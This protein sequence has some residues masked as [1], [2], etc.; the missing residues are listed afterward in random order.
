MGV[1]RKI[2]DLNLFE[3]EPIMS[4]ERRRV[5]NDL[6]LTGFAEFRNAC[7]L[8][9]YVLDFCER[10]RLAYVFSATPRENY[11]LHIVKVDVDFVVVK[12]VSVRK[13][14]DTGKPY[15]TLTLENL[16]GERV[17]Y[18]LRLDDGGSL[19][20]KTLLRSMGYKDP[21]FDVNLRGK[22]FYCR[23]WVET[24]EGSKY[25]KL[26]PIEVW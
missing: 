21:E 23:W 20:L 5:V 24:Y 9:P 16:K 22:S 2:S 14:T 12:N 1:N 4:C 6:L 15:V 7:D 11:R 26:K 25:V 18:H 3:P 10:A 17:P 13:Y 19:S 8:L